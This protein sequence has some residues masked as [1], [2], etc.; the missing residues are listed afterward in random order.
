MNI[1]YIINSCDKLKL[2][3]TNTTRAAEIENTLHFVSNQTKNCIGITKPTASHQRRGAVTFTSLL[4]R[5]AVVSADICQSLVCRVCWSVLVCW[6]AGVCSCMNRLLSESCMY[7]IMIVV[8]SPT[9]SVKL[10][11]TQ[12]QFNILIMC[13]T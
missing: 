3:C 6:S 8:C 7:Y 2:I 5:D 1:H 4:S 12:F 11:F 13:N 9:F 10:C